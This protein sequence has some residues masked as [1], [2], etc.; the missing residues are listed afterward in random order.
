L[1]APARRRRGLAVAWAM[2]IGVFMLGF[3]CGGVTVIAALSSAL[4]D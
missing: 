4:S 3:C 1:D 2:V